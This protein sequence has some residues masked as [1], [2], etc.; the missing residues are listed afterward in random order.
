M[1]RTNA[2]W[3]IVLLCALP[4]L[5]CC[6]NSSEPAAMHTVFLQHRQSV[7]CQTTRFY[8]EA[9]TPGFFVTDNRCGGNLIGCQS[10]DAF[11]E[12][13][14]F[15]SK[16]PF[17]QYYDEDSGA[18]QLT[19]YYDAYDGTGGGIR[20]FPSQPDR[21][22]E[23]FLFNSADKLHSSTFFTELAK[24]TD[25]DPYAQAAPDGYDPAQDSEIAHFQEARRQTDD[26][27]P[28]HYLA[29]GWI[30][31]LDPEEHMS[32]IVEI[33]W[34]YRED[35]SL[36][37]RSYRRN[38]FVYD[39]FNS[40]VQ[41]Y[42][43]TQGRLVHEQGYI[44][45]GSVDYYY[46]YQENARTPAYYLYIDHNLDRLDVH[47]L[48]CHDI[49]PDENGKQYGSVGPS[50]SDN[51]FVQ[52]VRKSGQYRPSEN[53]IHTYA[54]DY[55][56]DGAEEAYIITGELVDPYGDPNPDMITG[57]LWLVNSVHQAQ[58]L[59]RATFSAQQQYIRQDGKI[60]LFLTHDIGFPWT[61]DVFSVKDNASVDFP[62]GPCTKHISGD[63][64]VII[65]QNT[66]DSSLDLSWLDEGK[67]I[68]SG[69][70]WKP[71]PFEWNHE[72]WTEIP[73]RETSREEAE[74]VA[75]IPDMEG[76]SECDAIQYILR[77]NG[78]LNV[79][80]AHV[81]PEYQSVSF[82]YNT[83]RPGESG[84]WEL[85]DSA[86]GIYSIQL[87]EGICWDYLDSLMPADK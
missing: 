44:T 13:F 84:A 29:Q 60:Y 57:T 54:A 6:G 47:F 77:G 66:Y 85:S 1:R 55:D 37:Q 75:I 19:L 22:P 35:G 30:T 9:K 87:T 24:R 17:Y 32:D 42:Y 81:N 65:T 83:F 46:I 33:D 58:E 39:T 56:G 3:C 53:V 31:Y 76:Q 45:H 38:Y 4:V 49:V 8:E 11:L 36:K 34:T 50:L 48:S 41:G 23:G 67:Y 5:A 52:T 26:G 21:V 10:V 16:E 27:R 18:L 69:H 61:T 62:F 63:G 14:E 79:N 78:E 2:K 70:T 15:A 59:T 86:P 80:M 82:H 64:T 51:V 7:R 71:Y 25:A 68:F 74:A 28:L 40:A 43:D 73:A 12:T 20:Y 72:K